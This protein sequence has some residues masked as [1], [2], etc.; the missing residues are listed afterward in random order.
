MLTRIADRCLNGSLKN[1]KG[2]LNQ[3]LE[4]DFDFLQGSSLDTANL[5]RDTRG[6]V[7]R[8]R[9]QPEM[10][11]QAINCLK[12]ARESAVASLVTFQGSLS[13]SSIYKA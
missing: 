7:S 4:S 5:A 13:L 11:Q 6:Y 9:A 10:L 8:L 3:F 1:D 12:E 2:E